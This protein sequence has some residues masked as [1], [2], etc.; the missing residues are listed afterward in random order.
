MTFCKILAEAQNGKKTVTAIEEYEKFSS[1][2]RYS[3]VVSVDGIAVDVIRAVQ[4]RDE[5]LTHNTLNIDGGINIMWEARAEY[6]D[7][8]EVY[9]LFD[10]NPNLTEAENQYRIECWLIE[11]KDGC[12]WYSVNWI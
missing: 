3:V 12:T 7:G 6:Q 8:S 9:R 2:P 11:Q 5:R 1:A 10:N 4:R